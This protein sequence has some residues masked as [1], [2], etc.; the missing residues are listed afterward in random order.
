MELN[1]EREKVYVTRDAMDHLKT[2][3]N[4]IA[5]KTAKKYTYLSRAQHIAR[6]QKE[7]IDEQKRKADIIAQ[8]EK[9]LQTALDAEKQAT[10]DAAAN[11]SKEREK[12]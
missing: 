3:N 6:I 8:C 7:K 2:A 11:A 9:S 12:E 1:N 4:S 5:I 10:E